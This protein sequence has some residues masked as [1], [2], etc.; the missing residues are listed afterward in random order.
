MKRVAARGYSPLSKIKNVPNEH[1]WGPSGRNGSWPCENSEIN[2]YV[3]YAGSIR[4]GRDIYIYIY[5]YENFRPAQG[6]P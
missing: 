5:I 1:K 4:P 2:T 3:T 6:G